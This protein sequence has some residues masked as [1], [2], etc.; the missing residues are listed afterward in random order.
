MYKKLTINS[1]VISDRKEGWVL[2]FSTEG[3]RRLVEIPYFY[4][5]S[6]SFD[7]SSYIMHE[8][9]RIYIYIFMKFSEFIWVIF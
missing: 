4:V 3:E 9:L 7:F 8:F 1:S 5:C 6:F 2:N